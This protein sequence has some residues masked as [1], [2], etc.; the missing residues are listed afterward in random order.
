MGDVGCQTPARTL[1][2]VH[3]RSRMRCYLLAAWLLLFAPVL[4]GCGLANT[5]TTQTGGGRTP[6][7]ANPGEREGT[8]PASVSRP[9]V[10]ADPA[11]SPQ[12]AV[13]RFAVA[14]IN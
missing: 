10:P 9:A 14:Y 13:E 5:T 4:A 11:A 12:T 8:V 1:K 3:V 2:G 7:E 6:S